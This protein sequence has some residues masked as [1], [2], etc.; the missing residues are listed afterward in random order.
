MMSHEGTHEDEE[1]SFEAD[2]VTL[3]I[4]SIQEIGLEPDLLEDIFEPNFSVYNTHRISGSLSR[5]SG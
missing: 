4:E 5:I 2:S 3:P 1:S